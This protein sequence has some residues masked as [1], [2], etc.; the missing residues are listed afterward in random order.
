MEN[1]VMKTVTS[2]CIAALLGLASV[3]PVAAVE[4]KDV[5]MGIAAVVLLERVCGEKPSPY[6]FKGADL[7][8]EIHGITTADIMSQVA[9]ANGIIAVRPSAAAEMCPTMHHVV[10]GLEKLGRT[11]ETIGVKSKT[12]QNAAEGAAPS[13]ATESTTTDQGTLIR[14]HLISDREYAM[15]DTVLKQQKVAPA[16]LN[17]S[18]SVGTRVPET[19][20]FYPVPVEVIVVHPELR[21]Y[22]YILVGDQI[23]I[24]DPRTHEI[25]AFVCGTK[26]VPGC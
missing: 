6:A 3:G 22:N 21:G 7:Y 5:I 25:V 14:P 8:A 15:L 17:V 10:S 2:V 19:V 11:W 12:K 26:W 23:V 1:N 24:I 4:S 20:H 18:V 13:K 9:Y 16:K